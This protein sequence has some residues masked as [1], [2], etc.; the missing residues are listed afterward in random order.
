MS[1]LSLFAPACKE[2]G[3]TEPVVGSSITGTGHVCKRHNEREWGRALVRNKAGW[4][5]EM[6]ARLLA[7]PALAAAHP[8]PTQEADR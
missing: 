5:R 4:L 6:G 1:Q 8:N 3:C 2:P 7:K